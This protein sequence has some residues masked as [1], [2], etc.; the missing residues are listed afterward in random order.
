MAAKPST[1]V[2]LAV[3][4]A[5]GRGTS[6]ARWARD[7][8][9]RATVVA[10]AE[11]DAERRARFRAEHDL[12]EDA[13]FTDWRDLLDCPR[14]ADAVVIATQDAGHRDPAV[15]LTGLG[16]DV[17]LEKPLAPNE[18]DCRE[19]AASAE[20]AGVVFAVCH[21]LLYAPYTRVI[22][23]VIT[24]GRLGDVVNIQHLEPV[25]FWHQAHS[26]VRGNWRLAAESSSMLMA[27]S[28]HDIDWLQ[29]IVG[30]PATRV[31][32]FGGLR[33]FTAANRPDGAASRCVDCSLQETCTFSATRFYGG[34]L[35]AGDVGWPLDT[36]VG[37][38]TQEAVDEALARGPYGR[39]V[40]ACDNDVVDHQVVNLEFGSGA[41]ASFT[42]TAF[43][44]MGHRRTQI[45]GTKGEL[46]CDGR[47][48]TIREF[49]PQLGSGTTQIIDLS[50]VGDATAGGGHGGGDGGLMEAFIEAVS[51]RDTSGIHS[52]PAASLSSHRTV[53]AAERARERGT[54][55]A[56]R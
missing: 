53:F 20:A 34:L 16:Y 18:G 25:G 35:A 26:Y 37:E 47:V 40:Y 52:G 23:E 11:P 19:I 56:I 2:T 32:S 28:C 17:L 12:S 42:M 3:I 46:A 29:H 8:P 41:T 5:G 22:K 55:E 4:G 1:A 31:S 51:T 13:T 30:E 27:K 7:H 43:A 45:F 54:V 49:G 9:G 48:I 50:T 14:V 36:V 44:E 39:C 33:H 21:V 38:P 10:V 6:Y 15:A 24:S